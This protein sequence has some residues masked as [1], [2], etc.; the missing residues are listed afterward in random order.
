MK[1]AVAVLLA[2]VAILAWLLIAEVT[3]S[4]QLR[5]EL[6]DKTARE[7]LEF[8]EKCALQA[9]KI[10]DDPYYKDES[11]DKPGGSSQI[12]RSHYNAKLRK[13]FMVMTNNPSALL[14]NADFYS[15][16]LLDPI[17][18]RDFASY[19]K[20]PTEGKNKQSPPMP[21]F[22]CTLRHSSTNER[23]CVSYEEFKAF[24][25]IYMED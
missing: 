19:N 2:I 25:A 4:R 7:N 20:W 24:V 14:S 11:R 22:S 18:R 15:V 12:Y 6:A 1:A 10:F 17:E 8:Q 13:C 21:P 9:K 5:A 3:A 16:D 23:E